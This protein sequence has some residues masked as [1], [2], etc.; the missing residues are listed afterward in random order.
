MFFHSQFDDD[1]YN[2][3]STVEPK[4]EPEFQNLNCFNNDV[5]K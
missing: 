4:A 5:E 2:C 1:E 3:D